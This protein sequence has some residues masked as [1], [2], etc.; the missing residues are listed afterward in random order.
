MTAGREHRVPVPGGH[1]RVR[2]DGP[3]HA[4][5]LVF[6]NSLATDLTLWDPQVAAFALRFRMLRWDYRGHGGSD[7]AVSDI[8]LEALAVDAKSPPVVVQSWAG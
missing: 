1:L 8:G 2:I 4:P 3:L 6:S 5:W 7:P